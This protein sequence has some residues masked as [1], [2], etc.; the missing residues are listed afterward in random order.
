MTDLTL[1]NWLLAILIALIIA[2]FVTGSAYLDRRREEGGRTWL[3]EATRT[4]VLVNTIDGQ[5]IEGSLVRA[6]ADGIVVDAARHADAQ[7]T[8]AGVAFIP[9]ERV[10]WVQQPGGGTPA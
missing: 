10:S 8:I 4:R 3:E 7:Q 9:R 1:T 5:T 6:D 2:L